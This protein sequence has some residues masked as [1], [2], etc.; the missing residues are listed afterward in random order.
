MK[1]MTKTL[2]GYPPLLLLQA[3]HPVQVHHLLHLRP[4]SWWSSFAFL[5]VWSFSLDIGWKLGRQFLVS[6]LELFLPQAFLASPF[7]T[8]YQGL[9]PDFAA[10]SSQQDSPPR[11]HQFVL[12]THPQHHHCWPPSPLWQM[13]P[14]KAYLLKKYDCQK[15]CQLDRIFW[16]IAKFSL[17]N[18]NV[19]MGHTIGYWCYE[20]T[21]WTPW[22]LVE[23]LSLQPL[24]RFATLQA[25]SPSRSIWCHLLSVTLKKT[26]VSSCW[27]RTLFQRRRV[28]E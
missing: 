23:P 8:L 16:N 13:V 19:G 22:G 11:L 28:S 4:G 24:F 27:N 3:S 12:H 18:N 14:S 7:S 20:L 10:R 17:L 5:P 21:F 9:F 1:K 25:E 26:S 15:Q 2:P 6:A